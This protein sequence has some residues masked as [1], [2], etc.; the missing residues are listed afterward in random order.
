MRKNEAAYA[1]TA[2]ALR[3]R[4]LSGR[5][6][7]G[8]KLLPERELGRAFGVSRITVRHA[9]AI[10]EEETLVVRAQGRGTF[11]SRR[12]ERKIPIVNVDFTG[13]MRRHAPELSRAVRARRVIR[14]GA[15]LAAA[16][17]LPHRSAV[18]RVRRADRLGGRTVSVDE[19][20]IPL[21]DGDRLTETDWRAVDFEERWQAAQGLRLDYETQTIEAQPAAPP[22]TGWLRVARGTPLLKE[23]NRV[24]AA[25]GRMAGLFVSYYRHE[26][27]QFNAVARVSAR[28]GVG[29]R[30]T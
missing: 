29:R 19:V 21:R 28:V 8:A 17:D 3:G 5:W 9:L 15:D 14:A 1:V 6:K 4:I 26:Y 25:G 27:F 20:V 23:T 12:P 24:Y 18:W 2:Q 16:L 13:S 22:V 10:L 30:N 7:P 11:V